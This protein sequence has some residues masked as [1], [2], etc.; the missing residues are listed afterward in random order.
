MRVLIFNHTSGVGHFDAYLERVISDLSEDDVDICV[1]MPRPKTYASWAFNNYLAE[2]YNVEIYQA[3]GVFLF[4]CHFFGWAPAFGINLPL[5]GLI[6][7]FG[8]RIPFYLRK[9]SFN[10]SCFALPFRYW[11]HIFSTNRP[12]DLSWSYWIERVLTK[13]LGAFDRVFNTYLDGSFVGVPEKPKAPEVSHWYG[14][15]FNSDDSYEQHHCGTVWNEITKVYSV[16]PGHIHLAG[17]KERY[18]NEIV[19]VKASTR[20]RGLRKA[21]TKI[22]LIGHLSARKN[23]ALFM[24][25]AELV[26]KS[27][28]KDLA[29]EICGEVSGEVDE[30]VRKELA[31]LGARRFN[32]LSASLARVETEAEIN[33]KIQNADILW[34]LYDDHHGNSNIQFKARFFG[35]TCLVFENSYLSKSARSLCASIEIRRKDPRHIL[36]MIDKNKRAKNVRAF[37]GLRRKLGVA[38]I[39]DATAIRGS[40]DD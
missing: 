33:G 23:L 10:L 11:W 39:L 30:A 5:L 38:R 29:F 19:D 17:P 32:S 7:P 35:K 40:E 18:W 14:L 27:G 3:F 22:L 20:K 15:K 28:R 1:V 21:E 8:R 36:Q 12:F 16:S 31:Y 13:H 6:H 9:R 25:L 26:R 4:H 2:R 37:S 34:L 24:D